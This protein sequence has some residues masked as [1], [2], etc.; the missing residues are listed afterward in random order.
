[1]LIKHPEQII[2][3]AVSGM[4]S[5]NRLGRAIIKKLF[6]YSDAGKDHSAQNPIK[7]K[8]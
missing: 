1:M 7:I 8:V 4:L 5:K 6:V 2:T 3:D